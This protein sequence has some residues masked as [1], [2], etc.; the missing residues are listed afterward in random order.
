MAA[1]SQLHPDARAER[2]RLPAAAAP[3]AACRPCHRHA[4]RA[5]AG[6]AR[7]RRRH[8]RRGP[9]RDRGLRR[10]P[11]HPGPALRR[12]PRRAPA[13]P[14]RRAGDLP[15]RALRRRGRRHPAGARPGGP[16]CSWGVAPTR[17]C[18]GPGRLGD[19]WLATWCS[20]RRLQEALEL[21]DEQAAGAGRDGVRWRHTLQLWVGLD[22]EREAARRR[23]AAGMEAFYRVPFEAFE[24][25]TPYG[26]PEDVAAFLAPYRDAG[27]QR[28]N[29]TPCA[30]SAAEAVAMSAEVKRLLDGS[31]PRPRRRG[32]SHR[33]AARRRRAA[34]LAGPARPLQPAPA[35]AWRPSW[36]WA[37]PW[38]SSSS[39][40]C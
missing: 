3:P 14:G 17:R 19:G 5:G 1:L 23:V 21:C 13:A 11:P 27:V 24:R 33:H 18:G 6:P 25:Y 15:R 9:P 35:A 31:E 26:T 10:R 37:S 7:L 22:H 16:R 36:W 34:R 39:R 29:L 20:V 2:R 28:F 40:R 30:P 8:R 4:V 38:R 12:G 32:L